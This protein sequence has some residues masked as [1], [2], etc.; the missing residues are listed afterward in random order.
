MVK[1]TKQVPMEIKQIEAIDVVVKDSPTYD[2]FS[3]F[4]RKAADRELN[5]SE[6]DTVAHNLG[7]RLLNS[8]K[9]MAAEGF[10]KKIGGKK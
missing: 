3:D 6:D 5:W 7:R 4:M 1:S 9:G 10:L 2:S 8:Q